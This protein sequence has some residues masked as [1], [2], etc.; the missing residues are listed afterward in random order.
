[1]S[2]DH[3]VSVTLFDRDG[4]TPLKRLHRAYAMQWLDENDAPGSFSFTIPAEDDTQVTIGRIVKFSYGLGSTAYR[5]AG[6]IESITH[7]LTDDEDVVQ[8]SG[9]GVRALLEGAVVYQGSGDTDQTR[10]FTDTYPSAIMRTFLSEAHDRGTLTEVTAGFTNST[11]STG[12][13]FDSDSDLTIDVE[14]GTSL[15]DVADQHQEAVLDGVW[16]DANLELQ[17]ALVRG[18]DTTSTATPVVFRA[19]QNV[20]SYERSVTGPVRN[21][22]L[23]SFDDGDDVTEKQS[24]VSGTVSTYG[25]REQFLDLNNVSSQTKAERYAN[26]MMKRSA[27]PTDG[28]TLEV[29]DDGVKPYIDYGIGDYV[30]VIDKTGDRVKYRVRALTVTADGDGNVRVVPE[31]GTVQANLDDRLRKA[32]KRLEGRNANGDASSLSPPQSGLTTTVP[33][34]TLVIGSPIGGEFVYQSPSL[35]ADVIDTTDSG[36]RPETNAYHGVADPGNAAASGAGAICFL[37]DQT[38]ASLLSFNTADGTVSTLDLNMTTEPRSVSAGP[39]RL[40]V[41]SRG[42][43]S[44]QIAVIENGVA[45]TFTPAAPGSGFY[46]VGAGPSSDNAGVIGVWLPSGTTGSGT[47]ILVK[48]SPTGSTL[49]SQTFASPVSGNTATASIARVENGFVV[50]YMVSNNYVLLTQADL[51]DPVEVVG[52]LSGTNPVRVLGTISSDGYC[53]I[54]GADGTAT[55]YRLNCND[56]TLNVYPNALPVDRPLILGRSMVSVSATKAAWLGITSSQFNYTN[57]STGEP[58]TAT[59]Y[60]PTI[61]NIVEV[62]GVL[63]VTRS[64]LDG[65]FA[66]STTAAVN[67]GIEASPGALASNGD[68]C[69]FASRSS[70]GLSGLEATPYRRFLRV[71]GP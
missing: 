29:T 41:A 31:L 1:M 20:V 50:I 11:D 9:R 49:G 68:I 47:G 45:T 35:K 42:Q 27:D 37:R 24:T 22:T 66:V 39:N 63:N 38:P 16:V 34:G 28:A 56:R 57:S 36:L 8:V 55:I 21:V 15:A 61:M 64:Q 25:R 60:H 4:S 44:S 14:V 62:N 6:V 59:I 48:Y 54:S 53:W 52:S 5:W 43:A 40:V 19:T 12:A 58:A 71:A 65:A 13:S 7:R 2:A 69:F 33:G 18:T 10:S 32:L 70:G 30:W 46:L 3:F 26:K 17:Y 67:N 23:I 51:T